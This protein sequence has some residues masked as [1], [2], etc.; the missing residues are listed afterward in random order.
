MVKF[1][2]SKFRSQRGQ[3]LIELSLIAPLM[4]FLAYGAIEVGSVISAHLTMT[5]TSREGA[6]LISRGTAVN[7]A[8]DAIVAASSNTFGPANNAN[9]RIIYSRLEQDPA[10]PCPYA[11]PNPCYF[12][13]RPANISAT[14][15]PFRGGLTSKQSKLSATGAVDELV[16]IA[17]MIPGV[18]VVQPGQ[19]FHVV[20]VYYNYAP[21]IVTY[22]GKGI[23]SDFYDR[24]I[25]THVTGTP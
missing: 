18:N 4:V 15:G 22:V 24:T 13:K 14:N 8:L 25:F 12:I 6:N 7:T 10:L 3:S 9:W 19:T 1:F 5:H 2:K 20:E 21:H 23:N 16:N 11:P 17:G